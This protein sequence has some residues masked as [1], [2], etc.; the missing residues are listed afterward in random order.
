M[1]PVLEHLPLFLQTVDM[2]VFE[3]FHTIPKGVQM[4]SLHD[5]Q[6]VQLHVTQVFD[7]IECGALSTAKTTAVVQALA[8]E[9]ELTGILY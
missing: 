3:S 7:G 5:G 8:V 6:G 9:N 2:L 1:S 4:G